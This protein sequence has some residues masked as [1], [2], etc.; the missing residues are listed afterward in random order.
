MARKEKLFLVE[1]GDEKTNRDFGKL[2]LIREMPARQAERWAMRAL[3]AVARSGV[4]L[5]ENIVGGGMQ[6]IAMLGI[7]AIMRVRFEDVEDLLDELMECVSIVP[8]PKK[9]KLVRDLSEDDI[10]EVKTMIIL[11]KEVIELHVGFSQSGILSKQTSET[12]VPSSSSNIQMS[13]EASVQFS[14]QKVQ[15]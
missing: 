10:E 1:D 7:Q 12:S 11:R 9:P 8:D 6:S 13:P 2:F 5:P 3:L 14:R 4:D 15:R